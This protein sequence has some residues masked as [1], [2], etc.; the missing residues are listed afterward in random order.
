MR[1]LHYSLGLPPFR[2][3]GMTQ[4]C[5]DL[6]RFQSELGHQVGILW[7]GNFRGD[8]WKSKIKQKPDYQLEKGKF[9]A[10]FFIANALPVP[11][12][13]GISHIEIFASRRPLNDYDSFFAKNKF[14]VLH[15]HTL[16]GLPREVLVAAQKKGVKL[17]YTS[18]DYFGI[19]PK[20]SLVFNN[21]NCVD[22]Y[23]CSFCEVCNLTALSDIKLHFLQTQLY[24]KVKQS[25]IV[26]KLR[27]QHIQTINNTYNKDGLIKDENRRDGGR[28]KAL[29]EFY[30]TYFK[31]IDVIHFNS[32]NTRK[33][34]NCFLNMNDKAT[35]ISI[36]NAQIED[37][38]T[39][40]KINHELRIGYL[41]PASVKKGFY[42]LIEACDKLYESKKNFK[43]VVFNGYAGKE[44]IE[45]HDAYTRSELGA[46]MAQIDVLVVPSVWNETFGFTVLEALSYGIPPIVTD[47]VGAK[48][49][50][51]SGFNGK[52]VNNTNALIQLLKDITEK[53][54]IV[55]KWNENIVLHGHIKSMREHTEEILDVYHT[56]KEKC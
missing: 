26:R 32:S 22:P 9:A 35:T 3:G 36:S 13:D 55:E 33:V 39:V 49:L 17:I 45:T 31:M 41:G 30:Y 6:M 12:I 56:M 50:I 4:Y 23:T 28:Y 14:D 37:H 47:T 21:T 34:F 38:R 43:L 51:I 53:P 5:I 25:K 15:I 46:V 19:C 7:P 29:R 52:I 44:Y 42:L 2:K 16:M 10:N 24:K 40:R 48:D 1:I 27:M 8:R 11:L 20:T 54:E 18:H